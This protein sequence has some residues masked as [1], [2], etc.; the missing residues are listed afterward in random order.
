MKN[1]KLAVI[2]LE[3]PP[4]LTYLEEKTG[5][6]SSKME[7]SDVWKY[8]KDQNVNMDEL[9]LDEQFIWSVF[10]IYDS[11]A[12]IHYGPL[13]TIKISKK[14][15]VASKEIRSAYLCN[16][17]YFNAAEAAIG[18]IYFRNKDANN[19][20]IVFD[21]EYGKYKIKKVHSPISNFL[22]N[23]E[24]NGIVYF[25]ATTYGMS[26]KL[27]LL[28]TNILDTQ[29]YYSRFYKKIS[30]NELLNACPIFVAGRDDF[31]NSGKNPITGQVDFRVLESICKC[32]DGG[33]KYQ[34]DTKFLQDCLL[35][36]M[37]CDKHKVTS[38]IFYTT[39]ESLLDDEHKNTDIY[40]LYRQLVDETGINGLKNIQKCLGRTSTNINKLKHLLSIFQYETIRPKMF[41]Y[42]LLK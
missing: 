24:E 2:F 39:C 17:K 15:D 28:N 26:G 31:S 35:Y 20:S 7:H 6:K 30:K 3:N 40:K 4:Y 25:Q 1:K 36:T 8:M 27:A 34:K 13:K 10:N 18:L 5:K 9:N 33:T 12:Y 14:R 37:C 16:K 11:Y 38:N 23:D 19:E 42:E 21:S 32:G 41:E 29:V 22:K